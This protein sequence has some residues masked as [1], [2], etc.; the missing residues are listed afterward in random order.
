ME[1]ISGERRT[2]TSERDDVPSS[3]LVSVRRGVVGDRTSSDCQWL[4]GRVVTL[5]GGGRVGFDD[6]DGEGSDVGDGEGLE[7]GKGVGSDNGDGVGTDDGDGVGTDDG[8]GKGSDDGDGEGFDAGGGV[9]TGVV[10][11]V[12]SPWLVVGNCGACFFSHTILFAIPVVLLLMNRCCQC[13]TA[14]C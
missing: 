7:D 13:S 11:D 8:D 3:S 1:V 4:P 12:W 9:G 10:A 14:C 2:R 6:G 5:A